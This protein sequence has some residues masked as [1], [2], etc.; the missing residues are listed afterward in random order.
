MHYERS[1]GRC[2]YC[3][4]KL[5]DP[6]S[7]CL[8]H[9]LAR[10]RGG[11]NSDE[12]LVPCCRQCNNR[13]NTM[14]LETF[15]E[16]TRQRFFAFTPEQEDYLRSLGVEIPPYDERPQIVFAFEQNGWS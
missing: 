10:T 4:I 16:R 9:V 6:S 7:M 14:T 2:W 15:R 3:G 12:N 11:D 5:P 13:K 8:D 1:G